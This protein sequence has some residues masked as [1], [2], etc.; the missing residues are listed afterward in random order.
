MRFLFRSRNS[1]SR[2]RGFQRCSATRKS[3]GYA[4]GADRRG[5]PCSGVAQALWRQDD[6]VAKFPPSHRSTAAVRT[7]APYV[8]CTDGP[9]GVEGG[10][11]RSALINVILKLVVSNGG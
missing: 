5:S 1:G 2:M 9:D 3:C 7:G 4:A 6:I 11:L 8:R 10:Q